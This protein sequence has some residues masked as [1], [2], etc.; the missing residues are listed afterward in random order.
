MKKFL[1]IFLV[2]IFLLVAFALIF[3]HFNADSN[4]LMLSLIMDVFILPIA[5]ATFNFKFSSNILISLFL[6]L[7]F[8]SVKYFLEYYLLLDNIGEHDTGAL[9]IVF[10]LG[11]LL[12]TLYSIILNWQGKNMFFITDEKVLSKK[13]KTINTVFL[14]LLFCIFFEITNETGRY[15]L[16][17]RKFVRTSFGLSIYKNGK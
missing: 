17:I 16:E 8:I 12:A 14:I 1:I 2:N 4:F 13:S 11:T 3:W 15:N 6:T 7:L 9:F 5:L 10:F